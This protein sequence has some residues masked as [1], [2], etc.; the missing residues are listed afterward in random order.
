V[1]DPKAHHFPSRPFLALPNGEVGL[2]V[3]PERQH[4]AVTHSLFNN[5]LEYGM[6]LAEMKPWCNAV[7]CTKVWQQSLA[8]LQF[9]HIMLGYL[10]DIRGFDSRTYCYSGTGQVVHTN[11]PLLPRSTRSTLDCDQSNV[12][13]SRVMFWYTGLEL[14]GGWGFNPPSKF[15]Y[16]L[17]IIAGY[18]LSTLAAYGQPPELFFCNSNTAGTFLQICLLLISLYAVGWTVTVPYEMCPSS[19]R[20]RQ[21]SL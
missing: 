19:C 16:P 6:I 21:Q 5:A 10:R 11:V 13:S 3:G 1:T 18:R 2:T 20:E 8:S 12:Y 4:T 9:L 14:P 17:L 15:F 7:L